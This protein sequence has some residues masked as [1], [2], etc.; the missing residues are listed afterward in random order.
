MCH[1]PEKTKCHSFL[2]QSCG[3]RKLGMNSGSLET[4][5]ELPGR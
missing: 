5:E 3:P 1:A 2:V 4:E